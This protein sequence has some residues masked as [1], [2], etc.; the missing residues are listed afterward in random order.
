MMFFFSLVC[1]KAK[2]KERQFTYPR[3]RPTHSRQQYL[4]TK[5]TQSQGRRIGA[6][7]SQKST[8]PAT[9]IPMAHPRGDRSWTPATTSTRPRCC[10]RPRLITWAGWRPPSRCC[11]KRST[12]SGANPHR[13]RPRGHS[14]STPHF[15]QDIE[16]GLQLGQ[17][18][19]KDKTSPQADL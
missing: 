2:Y 15:F 4:N 18:S 12:M 10:L 19:R 8:R 5:S 14:S 7:V 1:P 13:V 9:T 6:N 11:Q 16:K 3:R 17:S